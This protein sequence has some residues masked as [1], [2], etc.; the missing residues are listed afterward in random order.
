MYA[1][2]Q[3]YKCIRTYS[4]AYIYMYKLTYAGQRV[5]ACKSRTR[6]SGTCTYVLIHCKYIYIYINSHMQA[7]MYMQAKSQEEH[8][9]EKLLNEIDQLKQEVITPA[10]V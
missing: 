2:K 1:H 9:Q 4:H 7:N 10:N 6:G 3:P 8:A 5:H